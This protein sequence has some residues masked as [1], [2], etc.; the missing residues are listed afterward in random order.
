VQKPQ[1]VISYSE[2]KNNN[3]ETNEIILSPFE[4]S[5]CDK[6]S[7]N[8]EAQ[9]ALL[10]KPRDFKLT[11]IISQQQQT[12]SIEIPQDVNYEQSMGRQSQCSMTS[13]TRGPSKF[14]TQCGYQ[15]Q[16]SSDKFC[17]S[18]GCKRK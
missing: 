5:N 6:Q 9:S 3:I 18:C 15:F 11:G 17:G 7:H 16:N 14:C 2:H 1:K 13:S 10:E 12:P 8:P 4:R